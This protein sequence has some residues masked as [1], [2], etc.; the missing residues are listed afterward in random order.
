MELN[1]VGGG[2]VNVEN[3]YKSECKNRHMVG[4]W[5]RV[6]AAALVF[7]SAVLLTEGI[8]MARTESKGKLNVQTTQVT[9]ITSKT[10]KTSEV[11]KKS[12]K[13]KEEGKSKDERKDFLEAN[14]DTSGFE[15]NIDYIINT[16]NKSS[17][18]EDPS[19]RSNSEQK[20]DIFREEVRM[21]YGRVEFDINS[22]QKSD[23]WNLSYS[24][25]RTLGISGIS[26]FTESNQ[27]LSSRED[28]NNVGVCF[29]V[30]NN[31]FIK[32]S[33]GGG[34]GVSNSNSINNSSYKEIKKYS[35][36]TEEVYLQSSNYEGSTSYYLPEVAC[37]LYLRY[38][39]PIN[40][41]LSGA[42]G[43][44]N[45]GWKSKTSFKSFIYDGEGNLISESSGEFS[46]QFYE[47][48]KKDKF[49][50]KISFPIVVGNTR[51]TM[52]V[53][54]YEYSVTNNKTSTVTEVTTMESRSTVGL[55]I[56]T[57][58]E[59]SKIFKILPGYYLTL[60][61]GYKYNHIKETTEVY[62]GY[63]GVETY[64]NHTASVGVGLK[65]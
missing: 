10:P 3:S 41:Q 6:R 32:V 53:P 17:S 16:E 22:S 45:V 12:Y 25:R 28:T 55:D 57:K 56:K 9:A 2:K 44:Y 60:G 39:L 29:S 54:W 18:A 61:V 34:L 62:G 47:S 38:I 52:F 30:F 1:L 50:A 63:R 51:N 23:R 42:S 46:R 64:S 19:F 24:D 65:F 11:S 48:Y 40:I 31:K 5:R 36:N 13:S 43:N 35:D 15:A 8:L 20:T 49:D 37:K 33:L 14:K 26:W 7:F 58:I 27:S 59:I 4:F 21:R